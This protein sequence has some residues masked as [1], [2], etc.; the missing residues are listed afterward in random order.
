[1]AGVGAEGKEMILMM[2]G[3][4]IVIPTRRAHRV[5]DAAE[6]RLRA[7]VRRKYVLRRFCSARWGKSNI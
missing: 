2:V 7:G 6:A 4:V 3:I 5:L 1:M